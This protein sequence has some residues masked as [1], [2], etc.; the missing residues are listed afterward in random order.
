MSKHY[1][2]SVEVEADNDI[3]AQ[4]RV[5]DAVK[6]ADDD[7]PVRFVKITNVEEV[8]KLPYKKL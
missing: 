2:V 3:H 8:T 7:N 6:Y 1:I 4:G 5:E